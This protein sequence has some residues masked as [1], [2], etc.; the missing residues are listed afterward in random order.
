MNDWFWSLLGWGICIF[1][2]LAGMGVASFLIQRGDK[3]TQ[4]ITITRPAKKKEE[5]PE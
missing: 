5:D 2:I 1:L 3:P 4:N